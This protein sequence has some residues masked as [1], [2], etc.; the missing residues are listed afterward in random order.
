MIRVKQFPENNYRAIFNTENGQT[1]RQKF[2][3]NLFYK[4]L[5]FPEILDISL[6]NKCFANCSF[7]YTSAIKNGE[8]YKNVVKKINSFFGK[9]NENERPFQ[10]AIGGGGEPT[11]H[12][13][14]S[15]VLKTFHNLKIMPNYTTNGMHLNDEIIKATKKYSGGVAISCHPHLTKI[16]E[17][18]IN[19]FL[20][21]KIRTNLHII[22][23][24][25]DSVDYFLKIYKKY[26]KK[27]EYFV[28][29]PYQ[30]IGRAKNIEVEKEW[31]KLFVE[32]KNFKDFSNIAFGA[33]FYNYFLKHKEILKFINLSLYPPEDLSGYLMLNDEKLIIRKSSYNL[34][35]KFKKQ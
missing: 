11:L 13:E 14:F 5:E 2:N 1:I 31:E 10:V 17:K 34:E 9:Q 26:H 28:L 35:P 7:C 6:G 27:I 18:S 21:N 19:I 22:I 33:L 15:E 30:A 25:K 20:K 32:L 16:W 23:G 3:S 29:L 8:N 12:P 24:E 4:P